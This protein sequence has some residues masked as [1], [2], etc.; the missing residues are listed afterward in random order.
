MIRPRGDNLN[1][2]LSLS[3][4]CC[5]LCPSMLALKTMLMS[6][7]MFADTIE[8]RNTCATPVNGAPSFSPV[9]HV[10]KFGIWIKNFRKMHRLVRCVLILHAAFIISSDMPYL[11]AYCVNVS[12]V[13]GINFKEKHLRRNQNL[14]NSIFSERFVNVLDQFV[15]VPSTDFVMKWSIP[16]TNVKHFFGKTIE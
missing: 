4:A 15:L 6:V 8:T 14:T 13:V 7:K 12:R 10:V 3:Y 1:L 2:C 9:L 16:S 11:L 5:C